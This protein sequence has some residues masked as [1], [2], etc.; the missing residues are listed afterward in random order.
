MKLKQE[1]SWARFAIITFGVG[2]QSDNPTEACVRLGEI[3]HNNDSAKLAQ[4]LAR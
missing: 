4:N 1:K 2:C 3:I